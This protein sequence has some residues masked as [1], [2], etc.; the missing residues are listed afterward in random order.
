MAIT[1]ET[2]Q[3]VVTAESS[4]YIEQMNQAAIATENLEQRI[5]KAVSAINRMSG[6]VVGEGMAES[7]EIGKRSLR[8]LDTEMDMLVEKRKK[9]ALSTS[10]ALKQIVQTTRPGDMRNSL[11]GMVRE[12]FK[13]DTADISKRIKQ[14]QTEINSVTKGTGTKQSQ[15]PFDRIDGQLQKAIGSLKVFSDKL[16]QANQTM[17]SMAKNA[18]TMANAFSSVAKTKAGR[19]MMTDKSVSRIGQEYAEVSQKAAMATKAAATFNSTAKKASSSFRNAGILD[20]FG[21]FFKMMLVF[22]GI[23]YIMS[24]FGRVLQ[25]AAKQSPQLASDLDRFKSS[26]TNI[27]ASIVVMALPLLHALVPALESASMKI[28][29]IGNAAAELIARVLGQDS[30]LR[31]TYAQDK[32]G[33]NGVAN[34]NKIKR[35]IMG[36]DELNLLNGKDAGGTSGSTGIDFIRT[37]IEG[38]KGFSISAFVQS[39]W[40]KYWREVG[41][42]L[43]DKLIE[44]WN[45]FKSSEWYRFFS[46]FGGWFHDNVWMPIKNSEFYR[47]FFEGGFKTALANLVPG[48]GRFGYDTGIAFRNFFQTTVSGIR[49]AWGQ[50]LTGDFAGAWTTLKTTF[51]KAFKDLFVDLRK[52]WMRFWTDIGLGD[53]GGQIW[54]AVMKAFEVTIN[55]Q[56][57]RLNSVIDAANKVLGLFGVAIP[58]IQTLQLV[59]STHT[60]SSGRTHGG[61]G[62][63]FAAYASGTVVEPNNPHLA[64]FGDNKSEQEIVSP[65][66]TMVSAFKAALGEMSGS[67]T[68]NVAIGSDR[69]GSAVIKSANFAALQSGRQTLRI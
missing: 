11:L 7:A 58:K 3:I 20:M 53:M 21:R 66:S 23:F 37:E 18:T 19:N 13:T 63:S 55:A 28:L 50:I 54:D 8:E 22:R 31:A 34:V 35:S 15:T 10:N 17:L 41:A 67:Q 47:F 16:I 25:D 51:R 29:D 52:G 5:S 24:N 44:M 9:L 1:V 56:I 33:D 4:R 46:G 6:R 69:L 49:I 64:W 40:N 38:A 61:A 43:Y 42:G 48:V 57:R 27:A 45:S 26:F 68:I 39:E 32:W 60:A 59:T 36:F 2:M 65:L 14:I 30:Y 62:R 12:G